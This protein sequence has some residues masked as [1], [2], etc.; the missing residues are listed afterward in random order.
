LIRLVDDFDPRASSGARGMRIEKRH[1]LLQTLGN[2]DVV[3][4][5]AC[6]VLAA[7]CSDAGV[8]RCRESIVRAAEN[9]DTVV[10]ARKFLGDGRA[11][12]GG[13]VI[14]HD[15]LECGER[16]LQDA[17]HRRLQE[18]FA[19]PDWEENGDPGSREQGVQYKGS[20]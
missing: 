6:D 1:L 4:I 3:G 8:Q 9:P 19:I 2:A 14:D 16:L 13:P 11:R 17:F 5:H 12:V 10:A 20:K 18:G 15:Q 7:R